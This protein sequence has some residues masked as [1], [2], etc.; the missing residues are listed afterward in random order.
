MR[1][2]IVL[3]IVILFFNQFIF[4]DEPLN[5]KLISKTVSIISENLLYVE[6]NPSHM[7][8]SEEVNNLIQQ[9]IAYRFT[10][11]DNL[12]PDIQYVFNLLYN[13]AY[14]S[15]EDM[16]DV[17]R[18]KTRLCLIFTIISLLS[19]EERG[20]TFLKY[21]R[22]SLK[23]AN[24]LTEEF[25]ESMYLVLLLLE[26]IYKYEYGYLSNFSGGWRKVYI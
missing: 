10:D 11:K 2:V 24:N 26:L 25:L 15:Y 6:G 3:F 12:V 9:A 14:S 17:R 1:L 8:E 21:A 20:F 7:E 16:P 23:G 18:M 4:S 13:N 5:R 22:Y 19:D